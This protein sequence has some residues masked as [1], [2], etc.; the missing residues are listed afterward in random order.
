MKG[1]RR[2]IWVLTGLVVGV[3]CLWVWGPASLQAGAITVCPV[4]CDYNTVQG[5]VNAAAPLSTILIS[6]A[7]YTETVIITKSLT[8]EGVGQPQPVVSGNDTGRPFTILGSV[9]VTMTNMT[10]T[11]G[12]APIDPDGSARGGGIFN[13]GQLT[14]DHITLSYNQVIGANGNVPGENG[15]PALGG[16]LYSDCG[17]V[18]C[19]F[20]FISDATIVSNT[21]QGGNGVNATDTQAGS[22]GGAGYGGGVYM[23]CDGNLGI[24]KCGFMSIADST[25]AYNRV[26]GGIGGAESSA[27]YA[28]RGGHV[29][30][31][32]I[33]YDCGGFHCRGMYLGDVQIHNNLAQGGNGG[34]AQGPFQGPGPANGYG[35]GVYMGPYSHIH[36]SDIH[37]NLARSGLYT[38]A[39]PHDG[40]MSM[41]GGVF[42][43]TTYG[44]LTHSAVWV[45]E[46][47]LGGGIAVVA[48]GI[49]LHN[50]TISR[51]LADKCGGGIFQASTGN[52]FFTYTTIADNTALAYSGSEGCDFGQSGSGGGI[53]T[54]TDVY[55]D[56]VIYA[57]NTLIGS[58]LEPNSSGTDCSGELRSQGFNLIGGTANC[59]I[60]GDTSG[61]ILDHNPLLG[62][63]QDN[64]GLTP[65]HA[66]LAGSLAI[67]AAASTDCPNTDQRQYLRWVDGNGD[68]IERC[69]MG[70]YEY[71]GAPTDVGLVGEV[72][73]RVPFPGI[74]LPLISLV[75]CFVLITW[76]KK[77]GT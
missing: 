47:D 24:Y 63:L 3:A 41:G 60:T 55:Y 14:L 29:Y 23:Y 42:T 72:R 35:G 67:D 69:D 56:G 18:I 48:S 22:I 27:Q 28:G 51:N 10:V 52:S 16:G 50:T 5:A 53:Y 44:G 58:N 9:A 65:T 68:G 26:I 1:L 75:A 13:Q 20:V 2:S 57:K 59:V 46:A 21:V 39:H 32:G 64:G 15:H 25:V 45:N 19:G 76:T 70:A 6:P 33:M 17:D 38:P 4:G 43:G 61:N 11:R 74:V 62:P 66:L 49:T 37:H 7:T 77:K 12:R 40:T 30:G 8:L 34:N 71:G 54:F 36:S 73:G 31:G